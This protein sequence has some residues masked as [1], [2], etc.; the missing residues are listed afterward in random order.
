LLI[1]NLKLIQ[2]ILNFFKKDITN[3]SQLDTS[4]TAESSNSKS[5]ESSLS[6]SIPETNN[7]NSSIASYLQTASLVPETPAKN[8]GMLSSFFQV[9]G[10]TPPALYKEA[11]SFKNN[12]DENIDKE[13]TLPNLLNTQEPE[14]FSESIHYFS[15]FLIFKINN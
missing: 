11:L 7:T 5:T 3:S 9:F 15:F 6:S 10:V 4:L 12:N 1:Q 14:I 8:S 13:L 2:N